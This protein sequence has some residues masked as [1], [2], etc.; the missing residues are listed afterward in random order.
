MNYYR[1]EWTC[2]RYNPKHHVALMYNLIE[3]IS[4]FFE[5]ESALIVGIILSHSRN[6]KIDIDKM[7]HKCNI[8]RSIILEF[9]E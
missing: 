3:G 9:L 7:L 8:E 6:A 1:P 5:A 2:G 4:F